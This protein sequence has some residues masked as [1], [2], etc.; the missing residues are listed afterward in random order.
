MKCK[1]SA[2]FLVPMISIYDFARLS[3]RSHETEL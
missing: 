2:S 1:K 3:S